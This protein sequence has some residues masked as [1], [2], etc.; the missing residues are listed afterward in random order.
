MNP[1]LLPHLPAVKG[2]VIRKDFYISKGRRIVAEVTNKGGGLYDL[3]LTVPSNMRFR[4][5]REQNITMAKIEFTFQAFVQNIDYLA[6]SRG[7]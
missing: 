2:E 1:S 5:I 7:M 3:F 6:V 4:S